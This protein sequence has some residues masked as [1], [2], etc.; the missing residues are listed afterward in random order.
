VRARP[1][2][3]GRRLPLLAWASGRRRTATVGRFEFPGDFGGGFA[4]IEQRAAA[5][6]YEH[7]RALIEALGQFFDRFELLI[8]L[9]VLALE[10]SGI[11]LSISSPLL[12]SVAV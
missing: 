3:A 5:F 4:D 6:F 7:G 1:V 2:P 11:A 8:E 10:R 12:T 9:A